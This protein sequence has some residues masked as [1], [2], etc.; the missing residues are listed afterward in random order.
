MP[1][2]PIRRLRRQ[3]TGSAW[4]AGCRYPFGSFDIDE[5]RIIHANQGACDLWQ[6]KSERELQSR[7]LTSD[8]STTVAQR[9]KQYQS[10]FV[11]R[12]ELFKET[13]T[14]YPNGTPTSVTVIFSGFPLRGGR[15][16]MQCEVIGS[17]AEE[18]PENLRSAEA[19]LHT[20]VMIMLYGA[21]GPP[22]YMNPAARNVALDPQSPFRDLFVDPDDHDALV[23]EIDRC[24]EHR[25]ISMIETV[26][27]IRWFD[28][29]ARHCLDAATGRPAT[30]VTAIDVS[31]LKNARD[32]AR[33]LAERDQLTGC[34]NRLFLQSRMAGLKELSDSPAVLIY[35]DIDHFKQINDQYGHEIGDQ[36][37]AEL[38]DRARAVLRESD[39]LARLGGDEFVILLENVTDA[40]AEAHKI[41]H[42]QKE[43]SRPFRRDMLQTDL[44]ISMGVAL[45]W[46]S[47]TDFETALHEAD[48]ALYKSKAEGTQSL[49]TLR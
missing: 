2:H 22:L 7:D 49:D 44:T 21:D 13:W 46:P 47:E 10:D 45:F 38:A 4:R 29:S 14:L 19:L 32:T 27:G 33:F 17:L 24:G 48:T 5:G 26:E 40:I 25:I 6:A 8:M 35:F 3:R 34:Y 16:A 1:G 43:L 30:L 36:V 18:S 28:V 15:M 23:F 42:I 39:V 41:D 9:L 37:L 31:E 11:D 20:D 12:D